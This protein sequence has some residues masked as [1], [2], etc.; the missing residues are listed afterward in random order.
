LGPTGTGK[1]RLAVKI[2]LAFKGEIVNADS[3]QVYRYMDIGTAKPNATELQAVPHHL[4]DIINPDEEFGLAQYQKLAF[5]TITDIHQ[6][7]KLPILVGGSGQYIWSVLEGWQIPHV[8]PNPDLRN[9]L[10]KIALEQGIEVLF[11]QLQT[12]DPQ[13]AA[14]IDPRNIRRVVRA[15][16]VTLQTDQPFSRLKKKID[17]GFSPFILGLTAERKELYKRVDARVDEMISQ[18]LERETKNLIDRAY[19][20]NLSAMNSIGYTQMGMYLRGEVSLEEAITLIKNDNHRFVRHQYAW[21]KLKDSR[22]HWLDVQTDIV[23]Q[24]L[25]LVNRWITQLVP[26]LKDAVWPEV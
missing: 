2:A 11:N 22:I 9:R 17:P 13:A 25:A 7:G 21:F 26:D 23:P 14:Q 8:R 19:G 16:E 1:S 4:Y 18:G 24:T 5:K 6:R 20:F 15:L 12:R 3:R 10:E